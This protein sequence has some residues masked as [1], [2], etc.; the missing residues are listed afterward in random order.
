LQSKNAAALSFYVIITVLMAILLT[1]IS[2]PI[3]MIV[4]IMLEM[5]ILLAIVVWHSK[6]IVYTCPS[7]GNSFSASAIVDFFSPHGVGG[8]GWKYLKCPRC[9]KMVK[10]LA[11]ERQ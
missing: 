5:G 3:G 4:W 10:A 11:K 6:I 7:C 2:W 8:G 9:G 1:P